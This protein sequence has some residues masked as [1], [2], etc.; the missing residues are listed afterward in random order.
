[1]GPFPEA[2]RYDY[3]LVVICWLTSLVNLIPTV[4]TARATD[5]VWA[6][7]KEIVHLHGLLDTIVLDRG[8]KFISKLWQDLHQLM[9][10]RLLMLMA[11]HPQ[12]DGM[13]GRAIRNVT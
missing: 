5:I 8:P 2:H 6:Y 4:T 12:T 3:L 11:Y 13:S 9:G 1:M 7:L 10:V